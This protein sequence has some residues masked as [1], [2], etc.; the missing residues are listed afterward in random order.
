[1]F[2]ANSVG[3]ALFVAIIKTVIQEEDRIE[4][5]QAEKILHI[6][7]R[8]LFHLRQGLNPSSA[9]E[10]IKIIYNTTKVSAISI[11]NQE[12]ILAHIG[13]GSDHHIP[14]NSI[15]TTATQEVLNTGELAIAKSKE[16]IDCNF[17]S[18]PLTSAIICPL[19][20]GDRVIGVLKFYFLNPKQIKPV[21]IELAQGLGNLLSHQLEVAE[22]EDQ[23]KLINMAE[24]KAL[25]AQI[26]PHFLFNSLNAVSALIRT[27]PDAARGLLIQLSSFLRKNLTS[28]QSELVTLKQ[29]L[30]H[31]RSFLNIE[32]VRFH[33]RLTSIIYVEPGLEDIL[34]PPLT[35]QPLV[36]NAIKHGLKDVASGWLISI[37]INRA[38]D[39]VKFIIKDN[40][41]GISLNNVQKL[42]VQKRIS[43]DSGLGLNN[44]HKRLIGHFGTKS[45]LDIK[46]A[47]EGGTVI[48]FELPIRKG[49][50]HDL[51]SVSSR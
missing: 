38:N 49:D 13:V 18:C 40:G 34:I 2:F 8:M 9:R 20:K 10:L 14:G 26:N 16:E 25:Q 3:A 21:D 39:K 36:E 4:A 15:L 1:M 45:G 24:I 47:P 7:D 37:S 33:D 12:I 48:T 28:C 29:E 51:K 31:T 5:N 22:A 23:A 30:E 43:S 17:P 32:K 46:N 41:V 42:L 11:T 50:N 27:D 35:I 44:V 6:A 19:T